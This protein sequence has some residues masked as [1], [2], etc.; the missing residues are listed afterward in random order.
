MRRSSTTRALQL[1]AFASL[2]ASSLA[3]MPP[4]EVA[5][6]RSDLE[7]AHA[8]LVETHP[9]PW[10]KTPR[11]EVERA[12]DSLSE[13]LPDLSP[14]AAMVA[15]AEVVASLGDGHTRLSLPIPFEAGFVDGHAPTEPP[16]LEALRFHVL[17]LRL[18]LYAEGVFVERIDQRHERIAGA[19]VVAVGGVPIEEAMRRLAPVIRHDN[20][21]QRSSSAI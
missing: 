3:A 4:D 12:F 8:R 21:E 2:M 15:L 20:E 16:A 19:Q 13:R 11:I 1:T 9:D 17:P 5:G 14:A 18:G 7:L 6:W 10:R